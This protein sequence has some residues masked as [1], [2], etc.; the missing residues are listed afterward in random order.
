MFTNTAG[1]YTT[2]GLV[3]YDVIEPLWSDGAVKT[4]WLA[5]PN[6]G[7]PYTPDEQ[8]SFAPTGEW[9]FPSGTIFVKHLELVTDETNPAAPRR[10]LETRLLVRDTNGAV[11]GVTYKWR[12]DNSDADLLADSLTENITITN[13]G[14]TRTQTWYYP[15]PSD[16]LQCHTTAANYVL[17]VKTRQ[18]DENFTYPGGQTDNQLRTLN[19]LGLF[20]PGH[21]RGQHQQLHASRGRDQPK[22]LAGRPRPL[23]Y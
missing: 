23:L 18:L 9:S 19:Q 15:S 20:Y 11:Y 4:R 7:T 12:P 2:N 1:L 8:I 16:C 21:R 6:N 22:R 3:P 13:A 14:G 17:G 5:V 10:R